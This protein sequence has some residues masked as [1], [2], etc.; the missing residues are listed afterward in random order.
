MT[1]IITYKNGHTETIRNCT[2]VE[3]DTALAYWEHNDSDLFDEMTEIG[4]L[5]VEKVEI[6]F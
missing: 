6:R 2:S 3:A 1:L 4:T 5:N